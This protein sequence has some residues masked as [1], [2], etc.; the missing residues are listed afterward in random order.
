MHTSPLVRRYP[1][2]VDRHV[3]VAEATRIMRRHGVGSLPVVDELGQVEGIFTE[4]D[5][6]KAVADDRDL[7]GTPVGLTMARNTV[8]VGEDVTLCDA[9]L[10]MCASHARHLPVTR[11][12]KLVGV[13]S[14]DDLVREMRQDVPADQPV[15]RV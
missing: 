8:T 3:S 11:G 13:I 6:V 2:T 9:A 5:I 15:E 1:I 12:T 7:N 4:S 10:A 14:V